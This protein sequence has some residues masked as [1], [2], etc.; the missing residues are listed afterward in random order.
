MFWADTLGRYYAHLLGAATASQDLCSG[1][2]GAVNTPWLTKSPASWNVP[3]RRKSDVPSYRSVI[4][5][6]TFKGLSRSWSL[7]KRKDIF[8]NYTKLFKQL[9]IPTGRGEISVVCT[10]YS[11]NPQIYI[12][13][14]GLAVNRLYTCLPSWLTDSKTDCRLIAGQLWEMPPRKGEDAGSVATGKLRPGSGRI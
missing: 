14:T 13:C 1:F 7:R 2:D 8:P 5:Y 3:P 6:H 4:S 11:F 9:A 10:R 12:R